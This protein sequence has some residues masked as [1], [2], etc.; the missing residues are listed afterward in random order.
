LV[1]ILE[2]TVMQHHG[3]QYMS[4]P[5]QHPTPA[6]RVTGIPDEIASAVRATLRSPG[7]GHPAYI[8][9]ATGYGPCRSCLATFRE[10]EEE[11]ILF[12]YQPFAAPGAL[13]A[14]GPVFIHRAPCRRYDAPAFPDGLRRLPLVLEAY[15][16][17]GGLL[18][19]DWVSGDTI[20]ELIEWQ[21]DRDEVAAVHVRNA[22]AGCFIA[23]IERA[24]TSAMLRP[25]VGSC[26]GSS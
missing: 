17:R 5:L 9:L 25:T 18:R 20:D 24:A 8:E 15:D 6:F 13:P 11:R 1:P 19:Q 26:V 3:Q 7:Y 22:E 21:L 16:D 23:R 14:P 2:G 12:T 4:H 10:G